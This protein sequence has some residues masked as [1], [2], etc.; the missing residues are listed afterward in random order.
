[1]GLG[2]VRPPPFSPLKVAEPPPWEWLGMAKGGDYD[3]LQF[4]I[5]FF[6]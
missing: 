5:I 3:H 1:M 2:V 4:I 6:L